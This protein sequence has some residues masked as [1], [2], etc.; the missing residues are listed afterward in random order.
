VAFVMESDLLY[1]YLLDA[2]SGA[3]ESVPSVI[4]PDT[5]AGTKRW[6]RQTVSAEVTGLTLAD[7]GVGFSLTGGTTPKTLSVPLAATLPGQDTGTAAPVAS[8]WTRGWI[9]WNTA[10]VAGGNVGWVCKC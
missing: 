4:S 8:T 5:N 2:D 3:S 1:A 6:I 7:L 9:R 10:P